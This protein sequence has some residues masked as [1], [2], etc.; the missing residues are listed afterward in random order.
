MPKAG[1]PGRPAKS[2]ATRERLIAAATLEFAARGFDGAKVDRIAARARINKAMLYY[3]FDGKAAL[4]RDILRDMFGAVGAQVAEVRQAG[5][6]PEAQ[7]GSFIRAVAREAL[8][9]PNFPAIWLREIAE[10]GRHI[11]ASIAVLMRRILDTL[12]EILA[13]GRATGVFVEVHPLVTQMGI[14][15]PLLLFAASAPLR[16]RFG[17]LVP[18]LVKKP[19]VDE[20]IHHVEATTLA[21]LTGAAVPGAST[22]SRRGHS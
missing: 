5:G 14:V 17:H 18:A 20:L 1:K 15:A 6:S 12:V 19:S 21:V 11:D 13:E 4:Y 3:H 2:G 9:R 8:T 16:E 22:P 10:G 7:I